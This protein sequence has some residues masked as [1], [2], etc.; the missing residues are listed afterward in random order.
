MTKDVVLLECGCSTSDMCQVHSPS[1]F[2]GVAPCWNNRGYWCLEEVPVR[3]L[4]VIGKTSV[5]ITVLIWCCPIIPDIPVCYTSMQRYL[6]SDWG[7]PANSFFSSYCTWTVM[8]LY[9]LVLIL[10]LQY[11]VYIYTLLHI[12]ETEKLW[13][14]IK[15]YIVYWSLQLHVM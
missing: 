15:K 11:H 8:C 12:K 9:I 2:F 13:T 7:W 5:V 10:I 4:L 3:S 1:G 6:T 14:V